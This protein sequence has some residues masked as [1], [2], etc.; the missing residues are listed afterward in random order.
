MANLS[1]N[2]SDYKSAIH[3]LV[4][5]DELEIQK[6]LE[7]SLLPQGYKIILAA[8]G[9]VGLL[10]M[11]SLR[12][13][14][15]ILDLGLPDM[16]G[17]EIV[18]K[19]RAH[20]HVPII[21]LS[22]RDQEQQRIIA[23]EAGA[24]DYLTKP[25]SAN[26]L[27]SRIKIVLNYSGH[28][29][30]NKAEVFYHKKLKVDLNKKLVALGEQSVNLSSVEYQLLSILVKYAGKIVTYNQLMKEIWG[31]F[32]KENNSYLRVYVQHLRQKL[33]DDPLKPIYIFAEPG[34]GYRL[35]ATV[36]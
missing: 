33:K 18:K 23:L 30:E 36:D 13:E 35:A 25:F 31:D 16:D 7:L 5:E 9:R 11:I 12:P 26:E 27:I 3:V 28:N 6:Y 32:T 29:N 34:I 10:Q 15:I 4:I 19:I 20:S 14:L 1:N 17:Q 2:Y 22:A 21:L 24:D 8:D